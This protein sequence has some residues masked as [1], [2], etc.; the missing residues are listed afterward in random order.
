[1]NNAMGTILPTLHYNQGILFQK[2][3]GCG[4]SFVVISR[5]SIPTS[6]FK[7]KVD[8][9]LFA[10]SLCSKGYGLGT[11]G[12]MVVGKVEVRKGAHGAEL[13]MYNPDGSWMGMCG[14][15]IR[16]VMRYLFESGLIGK[17]ILKVT[18]SAEIFFQ[19]GDRQVVCST[20]NR[21]AHV[22]VDMGE[23]VLEMSFLPALFVSQGI[24]QTLTV[25]DRTFSVT[26][27][28]M[29]NPHCVIFSESEE[30]HSNKDCREW[31]P[32][33]ETHQ[34]FPQRTNVEFVTVCSP[35]K[36]KVA[37]W[38]RGAGITLACGTGACAVVV[39]GVLRGLSN[40]KVKVELPGGVL[41][42]EW[43]QVS[44]HVFLEGPTELICKGEYFE[45]KRSDT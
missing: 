39:A 23:P 14:N 20:K 28:G 10:A 24:I 38:E 22:R 30:A 43:C 1:M 25:H 12:L 29:G 18:D 16:C 34:M 8:F 26:C 15:G 3:Q 21:G 11:D 9:A 27:V 5:E 35:S 19:V 37:V 33:I 13:F 40:R 31:G 45:V 7:S 42:V 6:L 32:L 2:I 41:D 44:N 4:N 36:S 17:D